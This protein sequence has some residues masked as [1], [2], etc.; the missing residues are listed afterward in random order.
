MAGP[1]FTP[2]ISLG[3]VLTIAGGALAFAFAWGNLD[4]RLASVEE[5]TRDNAVEIDQ[6]RASALG[7]ARAI[8][9]R[10]RSAET[11]VARQDERWTSVQ[12]QLSRIEVTLNRLTT[13][14]DENRN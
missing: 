12:T 7:E 10:L 3:N 11:A 2:Q 13:R 5:A 6:Q 4:G 9:A 8:E 1:K 14:L